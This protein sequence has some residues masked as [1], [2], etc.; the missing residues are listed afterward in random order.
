MENKKK[1]AF[2]VVFLILVFAGTIYGVFHG[3]DLGEIARIL[4]TVNLLWLI[5]GFICVIVFIWGESI[6][7][8]YMM[9]T[10]GIKKKK[11]GPA[12]CFRLLDFS[13]VVL[14]RLLRGDS[15]HRFI[16]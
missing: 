7:I 2:N 13:L 16:I 4:K 11:S 14:R 8:Y 3:E 1:M 12:F 5:P 9:R 15:L 6:I 10:L